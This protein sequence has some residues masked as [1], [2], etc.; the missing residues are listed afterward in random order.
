MI[1]TMYILMAMFAVLFVTDIILLLAVSY[2]KQ[3]DRTVFAV[4]V[5]AGLTFVAS[6]L[7]GIVTIALYLGGF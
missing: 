5:S 4:K 6:I 1:R 7:C 3:K 2:T